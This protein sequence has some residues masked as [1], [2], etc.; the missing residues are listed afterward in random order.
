MV[1]VTHRCNMACRNCYLP[2]RDLPDLDTDWLVRILERL[3]RRT[4]IRL[5]GAEPTVRDDLPD[6]IHRVRAAGHTPILLSNGLK[7]RRRSYVRELKAAGLGSVY[8]S[9]NGGLDDDLYL[10]IDGMRCAAA[11]TEALAHLVAEKMYVSIG[12][13][14]VRGVNEDQPGALLRHVA[15]RREVRELHLRSVGPIG[16]YIDL[17]PLT[18]ADLVRVFCACSGATPAS[19]ERHRRDGKSY[20]D[21]THGAGLRVQL[22]QWPDLGSSSR[23]RLAPDG[24][25]QPFFE[26]VMANEGGY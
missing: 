16:R 22:T 20:I 2:N 9:M 26:H 13:I 25:I 24:T 5:V 7:L 15:G 6:I 19:I 10:A 8:L 14:L 3:P 11:K 21:F 4:M 17:E 18:L 1:D 12:M 23:G